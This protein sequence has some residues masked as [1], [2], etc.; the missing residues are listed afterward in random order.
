MAGNGLTPKPHS[1]GRIIAAVLAV[2]LAAAIFFC[3]SLPGS[4]FPAHPDFLNTVVHFFSYLALAVLVTLALNSPRRKLWL[5]ALLALIIVSLYGASDE[6]HQLFVAGRVA[7]PLDWLTDTLGALIGAVAT[8]WV[9]SA[10]RVR[11]SRQRDNQ[12]RI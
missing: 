6:I 3:S 12:T 2:L 1:G 4:S 9:I 11:R 5:T 10:R 7:D 8:I